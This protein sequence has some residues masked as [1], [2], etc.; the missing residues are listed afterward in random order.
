MIGR[1]LLIWSSAIIIAVNVPRLVGYH[2]GEFSNAAQPAA[3]LIDASAPASRSYVLKSDDQGH[4]RGRFRINSRAID[5]MVDTGATFV[6][7]NESAARNLGYGGTELDFR[8]E[9]TTANGKVKAAHIL[10]KTVEIGTVKVRDVDAL[11]IRDQSLN[12]AL[13]GMSFMKK[14]SSYSSEDNQLSLVN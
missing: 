7:L 14:L 5:A 13:I 12:T 9:V 2:S 8:Y 4:Y 6:T 11:V 10:L 1:A 3:Q